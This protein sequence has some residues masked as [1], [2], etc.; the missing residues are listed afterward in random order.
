MHHLQ[1]QATLNILV[2]C[3][4]CTNLICKTGIRSGGHHMSPCGKAPLA[5]EMHFA[6]CLQSATSMQNPICVL[7]YPW[8]LLGT[9]GFVTMMNSAEY[10]FAEVIACLGALVTGP[11][12]QPSGREEA[13]KMKTKLFIFLPLTSQKVERWGCHKQS[14]RLS[15]E[16]AER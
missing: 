1:C 10:V 5:T 16:E 7:G 3:P 15:V 13:T 12:V 4:T 8:L 11:S 2:L 14:S 6:L 9:A